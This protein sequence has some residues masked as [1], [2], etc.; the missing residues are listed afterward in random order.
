MDPDGE[1][2]LSLADTTR[3][4]QI[5]LNKPGFYEVYTPGRETVVAANIDSRESDLTRIEQ[6]VL[7][8]WKD[9]TDG[10]PAADGAT[11]EAEATETVELW[12]WA[13]L[14]LAAIVIGESIL[15]NM[16]LTP[17]RMENA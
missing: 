13:L 5:K 4:Q 7:D 17:R 3:E 6:S 9:S 11:F 14:L 2:V 16:H 1:T 8:R 10:Q 12:H 15:G